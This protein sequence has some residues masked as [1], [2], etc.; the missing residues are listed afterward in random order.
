MLGVH[1]KIAYIEDGLNRCTIQQLKLCLGHGVP[2]IIKVH[3]VSEKEQ[4][5]RD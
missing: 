3:A 4:Q 2:G 1:N 5:D